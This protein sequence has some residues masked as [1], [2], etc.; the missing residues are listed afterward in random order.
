VGCAAGHVGLGASWVC[1]GLPRRKSL[2]GISLRPEH[3]RRYKDL[4]LLLRR[5]GGRGLRPQRG[6]VR[7][8][9]P[10]GGRRRSSPK[11]EQLAADLEEL[12]P[13]LH[14]ARP[15]AVDALGPAARGVPPGAEPPPGRRRADPVRR[16]RGGLRRRARRAA[17]PGVRRGRRDPI[18]SASLAQVHRGVLRSGR[19]VAL[20]VQRPGIRERIATDLDVLGDIAELLDQHTERAALPV[21]RAAR[22]VPQVAPA[23]ARLRARGAQPQRA[24]AAS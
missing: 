16:R 9:R 5:Y 7:H 12:G 2:M 20:K 21:R 13:D 11:A 3:L 1:N 19:E 14:Q 18:G 8:A 17:E 15:A 24:R 10:G 6:L 4:A 23:R 22:G